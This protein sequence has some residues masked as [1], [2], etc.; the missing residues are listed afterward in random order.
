MSEAQAEASSDA[1]R[2]RRD[3]A[4]FAIGLGAAGCIIGL[5]LGAIWVIWIVMAAVF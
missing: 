2:R 5:Y 1:A 3:W 4:G